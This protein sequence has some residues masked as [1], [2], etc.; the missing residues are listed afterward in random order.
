MHTNETF[1]AAYLSFGNIS[2]CSLLTD[3]LDEVCYIC[4][5]EYYADSS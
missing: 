4:T 1:I 3:C 5:V 2:K